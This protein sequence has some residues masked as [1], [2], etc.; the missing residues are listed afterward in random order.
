MKKGQIVSQTDI[1]AS[2]GNLLARGGTFNGQPFLR[3]DRSG[4]GMGH[5]GSLG[6]S[7]DFEAPG[8]PAINKIMPDFRVITRQATKLL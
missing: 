6:K 8:T 7:R 5:Q 2:K 4:E 3:L 1:A